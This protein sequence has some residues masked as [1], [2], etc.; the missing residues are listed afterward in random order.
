MSLSTLIQ[1]SQIEDIRALYGTGRYE[2]AMTHKRFAVYSVR[3]GSWPEKGYICHADVFQNF[4]TGLA[5]SLKNQ[6][7]LEKKPSFGIKQKALVRRNN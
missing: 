5:D 2:L 4:T 1:Q 6:K 7:L 3:W